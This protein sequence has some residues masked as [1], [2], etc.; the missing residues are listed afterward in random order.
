[1]PPQR[2]ASAGT[3]GVAAPGSGGEG[4]VLRTPQAIGS[5]W[6]VEAGGVRAAAA[7]EESL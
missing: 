7:E 4:L 2:K 1:M 3:A 6:S 5:P